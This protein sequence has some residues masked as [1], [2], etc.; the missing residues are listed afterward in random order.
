V[1]QLPLSYYSDIIKGIKMDEEIKRG[2]Y[3]ES[4]TADFTTP[5]WNACHN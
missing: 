2:K 3:Y 5:I 4:V 1:C